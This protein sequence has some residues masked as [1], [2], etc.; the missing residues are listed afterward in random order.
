MIPQTIFIERMAEL[1]HSEDAGA[2]ANAQQLSL[3]FE[4]RQIA[5]QRVVLESGV[6]AGLKLPRGTVLREGDVLRSEDNQ[7]VQVRAAAELVSIIHCT[8]A[9]QLAKAAYHLGNRHV[10][11]QV[12]SG[13]L[14]YLHDHVLDEMLAGLGMEVATEQAPFEPEAGAYSS[15]TTHAHGSHSHGSHTHSHEH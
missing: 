3:P 14:R 10:W 8:D 11:V 15:D 5:R 13:W 12:G 1:S 7:Y 6:E 4:R 9:Q 2:L